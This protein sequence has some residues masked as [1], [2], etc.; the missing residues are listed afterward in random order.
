MDNTQQLFIIGNPRSGTSL[1]RIMM[2]SHSSMVIPPECGFI[3]WWF[4]KYGNWSS[5]SNLS[6]FISDLQT[7][8]KIE[9]WQLDFDALYYFLEQC[10]SKSYGELVF[11]VIDFYG[12]SK[13]KKKDSIVLGDKNNYY[14]EHLD[15]LRKITPTAK[16]LIIL[17]DPRDVYCSY[18]GIAELKSTATYLPKLSQSLKS[19]LRDWC[20][21]HSEILKFTQIIDSKQFTVINYED[22]ILE[23][24]TELVKVCDFLELSFD[25]NM[26]QYYKTND[27]PKALLDWKKKTLQP[28]DSSSIGRYKKLLLKSEA[29]KIEEETFELY[30]Q[31]KQG[32]C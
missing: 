11:N 16:F 4:K 6:E 25:E 5:K 23:S 7:S 28:P 27:E 21:N 20:Q 19:F 1:L 9:T 22:L 15:L 29:K 17:R 14:I 24:K 3:Q 13:H 32:I 26:L 18:K 12:R 8:K 30:E 31:L 10:V 2:N